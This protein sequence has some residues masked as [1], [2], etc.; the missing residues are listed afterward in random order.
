MSGVG[1]RSAP[2]YNISAPSNYVAGIG[3][4]ALG[5]T[6]RSDIGPARPATGAPSVDAAFGQPPPG[7]VAG[8]GRGMGDLA[9]SQGVAAPVPAATE[10][11]RMDYSESNYDEFTGYSERLFS[12]A[13]YEED[14]VEADAIYTSVDDAME[15]RR[16]RVR[17]KQLIQDQLKRSKHERPRIADQ[18]A[19]LKRDLAAVSVAEWDAIP[20]IGDHSLKLKQTRKKDSFMPLPDSVMLQN[21]QVTA[22]ERS[23]DPLEGA[24]TSLGR[25]SSVLTSRLD[26]ISDSVSGQTVVDPKGYLTSLSAIKVSSEAEVGDI[27][28]ARVL[29]QS[30][31]STNPTHGPGWIAA[32]RVEEYANKIVA[33]RK[34]IL[35]GC[36]KAPHSEDVWLEAS[37]LHPPDKAR[38]ILRNALRALP[39]SVKLYLQLASQ[40]ERVEEK[41]AI[42][43]LGLENVP[44]SVTLWKAAVDLE[45]AQDAKILLSR[46]IECIPKC[47]DVYLALARLETHAAARKVLNLARENLPTERKVWIMAAVLEEVNGQ[48][49]LVGR[50]L[51]KMLL[52]L[53]Q[54]EVI[55][56]REDWL[57]E[58]VDCELLHGAPITC[59]ALVSRTIM[60]GLDVEDRKRVMLEDVQ[61]L[62]YEGRSASNS[63]SPKI[64]LMTARAILD[65]TINAFPQRRSI[66]LA[67]IALEQDF[68]DSNLLF[69]RL[70]QACH[71]LPQVEVFWLLYA[72]ELWTTAGD[73]KAAREV[74]MRGFQANPASEEIYLAAIKLEW[75]A[76][77]I[78][79]ARAL[80]KKAVD[81]LPQPS[82]R[83]FL[84][85]ALFER[86]EGA[87]EACV[88]TL[89]L[90]IQRFSTFTKYYLMLG[91]VLGED[92]H[93]IDQ[94][95][96]AFQDGLKTIP[97]CATLWKAL[98]RLE[99][100]SRGLLKA[101]SIGEKARLSC[102]KN[103]EVW[104]ECLRLERR[105]AQA[106][107]SI[108]NA[109]L[110]K[111]YQGLA[112]RALADCPTSGLVHKEILLHIPRNQY[113]SRAV[114][115]LKKCSQD[116]EALLAVARLFD[117]CHLPLKATKY[118]ERA[119]ALQPRHGDVYV[120]YWVC[121]YV[122]RHKRD[123]AT[124]L[125]EEIRVGS[126]EPLMADAEESVHYRRTI[127][128]VQ[129]V[130]GQQE[131]D[132]NEVSTRGEEKEDE[133]RE[134]MAG[135]DDD[136]DES[137]DALTSPTLPDAS[138]KVEDASVLSASASASSDVLAKLTRRCEI[139]EPNMGELWCSFTKQVSIRRLPVREKLKR[140]VEHVLGF[141]LLP[142]TFV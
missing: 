24:A 136:D 102:P 48:S 94:A 57:A 46:A 41:K 79:R 90:G 25:Q 33:A 2:T 65:V 42:L 75:E 98:L 21:N 70:E 67:A 96:I 130:H 64:P 141:Q 60:V 95:R 92:L 128:A 55:V 30:V 3:R 32:A 108:T 1:P 47:L 87:F 135:V 83:L 121:L 17:E 40:E 85:K 34:V 14:D 50:I 84:K 138:S 44:N 140:V 35:D 104:V 137:P 116:S 23:V 105:H 43:R 106:S 63:S 22:L 132:T 10:M 29:L 115:A 53:A 15:A 59:Q 61:H 66:Y 38:V 69:R 56:K 45:D 120:Y 4:G 111:H 91:Q 131:D 107:T 139:A 9:R 73:V 8:L 20:E 28:K 19:D 101:R 6:T 99:E 39:Q 31:T 133:G 114:E 125:E 142:D 97:T 16:K 26:K 93:N 103:A 89:R 77:E 7:Y 37:R 127:A 49:Q 80:L 18:F 119:L 123:L 13:A 113:K 117:R 86:E 124:Y 81:H 54:L 74:L 5:F 51:D 112:A 11:D 82:P 109:V 78:D 71:A 100:T 52:S 110:S 126:G 12:H 118:F 134:A 68:G 129:R 122:Q 76:G 88:A 62:I 58:A 72:K 27:K 36:E